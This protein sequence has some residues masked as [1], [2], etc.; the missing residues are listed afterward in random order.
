M[1]YSQ[2]STSSSHVLFLKQDGTVWGLGSNNNGQLGFE[3]NVA[4]IT[5]PMQISNLSSIIQVIAGLGFS[6][7][8]K[9]DGT[10]WVCGLNLSGRIGLPQSVTNQYG[11][12]PI[13]NLSHVISIA[14]GDT[15]SLFLRADG[16]VYGCGGNAKSQL[17]MKRDIH[18][19]YG[20]IPLSIENV[21]Q[22]SAAGNHSMFLQTDGSVWIAGSFIYGLTT[23]LSTNFIQK[24]SNIPNVRYISVSNGFLLFIDKEGNVWG[25]GSNEH[26][27]LGSARSY[28]V[29]LLYTSSDGVIGIYPVS[30][31]YSVFVFDNGTIAMKGWKRSHLRPVDIWGIRDVVSLSGTVKNIY[32]LN[33][34]GK[35]IERDSDGNQRVYT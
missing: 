11:V 33:R 17:G 15:H 1:S 25:V 3:K 8:L 6:L 5:S 16:S 31:L 24:V 10:V 29:T 9:R 22:V 19:Q 34:D 7:F 12:A 2:V 18:S 13:S 28:T 30:D 23:I 32:F 4:F 26:E 20:V 35:V 27:Q 21:V 14:S